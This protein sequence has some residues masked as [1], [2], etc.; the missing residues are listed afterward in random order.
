MP[1]LSNVEAPL[2]P[3]RNKRRRIVTSSLTPSSSSSTHKVPSTSCCSSIACNP[4]RLA[5]LDEFE[6]EIDDDFSVTH[7]KTLSE[8]VS[9]NSD[10]IQENVDRTTSD[11][12]VDYEKPERNTKPN[13]DHTSFI[14]LNSVSKMIGSAVHVHFCGGEL[15]SPTSN[16]SEEE[17]FVR[18]PLKADCDTPTMNPSSLEAHKITSHQLSNLA[19]VSM[20]PLM[21]PKFAK[22]NVGR[23]DVVS[24]DEVQSGRL[25]I[26]RNRLFS[27]YATVLEKNLDKFEMYALRNVFKVNEK[28]VS[29]I[30]TDI[31]EELIESVENDI[32]SLQMKLEH[33]TSKTK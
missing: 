20:S 16:D 22:L 23:D 7:E 31:I 3:A 8:I 19:R 25:A 4:T 11:L 10:D 14:F 21:T 27:K 15:P 24:S 28:S 32:T 1:R 9:V 33:M 13:D 5:L 26:I 29:D 17:I 12:N 30:P 6:P 2:T 18:S